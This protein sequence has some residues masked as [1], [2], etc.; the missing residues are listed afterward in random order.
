MK[1]K[2]F[3]LENVKSAFVKN[4]PGFLISVGIEMVFAAT[5]VAV[6]LNKK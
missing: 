4:L 5:H 2:I 6:K 1:K 3:T